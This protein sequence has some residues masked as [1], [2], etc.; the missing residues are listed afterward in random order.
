MSLLSRPVCRSWRKSEWT[1][2]AKEEAEHF[3]KCNSCE[4][5][6]PHYD[7]WGGRFHDY[8]EQ[9]MA[10][11]A[12]AEPPELTLR[13]CVPSTDADGATVEIAV[14]RLRRDEPRTFR[15]VI[16]AV[17]ASRSMDRDAYCWKIV[18]CP[19]QDL[20]GEE[21]ASCF[22]RL[23]MPGEADYWESESSYCRRLIASPKCEASSA[24]PTPPS[25]DLLNGPPPEGDASPAVWKAWHERN[26]GGCFK[27]WHQKQ[28]AVRYRCPAVW[29]LRLQGVAHGVTIEC[30]ADAPLRSAVAAF[31]AAAEAA[32]GDPMEPSELLIKDDEGGVLD[33][34]TTT[35]RS[36]FYGARSSPKTLQVVFRDEKRREA[37]LR[38]KH[39]KVPDGYM[40]FSGRGYLVEDTEAPW[41]VSEAHGLAAYN[42][43]AKGA[44]GVYE[45]TNYG[46]RVGGVP[47]YDP[48]ASWWEM[49]KLLKKD[50]AS[51]AR[52]PK[53]GWSL[54]TCERAIDKF[55][56]I[57]LVTQRNDEWR[58]DAFGK[59]MGWDPECR[60]E[61]INIMKRMD[62]V[63]VKLI[64]AA[65]ALL[66]Q[67]DEPGVPDGMLGLPRILA[68]TK[69]LLLKQQED[70]KGYSTPGYDHHRG[71]LSFSKAIPLLS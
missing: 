44:M 33:P 49:C 37:A 6:P 25:F 10:A 42:A 7:A 13:I 71:Y 56:G 27:F 16:E 51:V 67:A 57:L 40:Q 54:A 65:K 32:G 29:P 19:R 47:S 26:S 1:A 9:K 62:D 11:K 3:K 14:E 17:C 41:L 50:I 38:A 35:A 8:L 36:L 53:G 21:D 66:S 30:A 46:E 20:L 12:W 58:R 39:G 24:A 28:E 4:R 34:W 63:A 31:A 45:G 52:K 68:Q 60:K 23:W 5:K 59:I 48:I 61:S 2:W 64:T 18:G 15:A 43:V 55:T 70:Y 69:R 22:S